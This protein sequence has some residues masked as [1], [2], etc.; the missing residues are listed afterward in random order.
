[1]V[2]A[3]IYNVSSYRLPAL[4][5]R[6]ILLLLCLP[7][8]LLLLLLFGSHECPQPLNVPQV[9]PLALVALTTLHTS[10]QT[11]LV[12]NLL[13]LLPIVEHSTTKASSSWNFQQARDCSHGSRPSPACAT[14]CA[15]HMSTTA[16]YTPGLYYGDLL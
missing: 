2:A 10:T 1:M 11:M 8:V 16:A 6:L 3:V 7:F 13:N 4:H 5:I 15:C 14:D 12:I 9:T